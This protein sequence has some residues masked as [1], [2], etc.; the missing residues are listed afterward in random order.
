[1]NQEAINA[2]W[3]VDAPKG[4][5]EHATRVRPNHRL[6]YFDTLSPVHLSVKRFTLGT[7][8]AVSRLV[9]G[10]DFPAL[11]PRSAESA[12]ARAV[13]RSRAPRRTSSSVRRARGSP[14]TM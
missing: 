10:F 9:A 5:M 11:V 7:R 13:R 12:F 4:T 8:A 6:G 2:A 3:L 1:E 14:A